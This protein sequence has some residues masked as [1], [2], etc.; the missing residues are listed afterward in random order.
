MLIS[1]FC[2]AMLRLLLL[3]YD[4]TLI[5]NFIYRTPFSLVTHIYHFFTARELGISYTLLRH[6]W[7]Y[8]NILWREEIERIGMDSAQLENSYIAERELCV[9]ALPYQDIDQGIREEEGD[10]D[11][12]AE[13]SPQPPN[14]QTHRRAHSDGSTRFEV[15]GSGAPDAAALHTPAVSSSA[16]SSAASSSAASASAFSATAFSEH[17]LCPLRPPGG[18][19]AHVFLASNDDITPSASI[20]AYLSASIDIQERKWGKGQ[21]MI[22]CEVFPGIGHAVSWGHAATNMRKRSLES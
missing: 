15:M 5:Y 4:P 17:P 3:S 6:F 9:A 20:D 1:C 13:E 18:I 16:A 2:V 7:W 14:H 12:D 21:A 19:R 10:A 22:R 8:E 11:E